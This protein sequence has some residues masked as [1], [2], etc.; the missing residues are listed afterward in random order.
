MHFVT[1]SFAMS[2]ETSGVEHPAL[3]PKDDQNLRGQVV[4][5]QQYVFSH[6]SPGMAIKQVSF[7]YPQI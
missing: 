1:E 3:P 2:K 4:G 5:G 7:A 6:Q